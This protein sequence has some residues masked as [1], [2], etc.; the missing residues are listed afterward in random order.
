MLYLRGVFDTTV[1]RRSLRYILA[2]RPDVVVTELPVAHLVLQ[3]APTR[4]WEAIDSFRAE[5]CVGEGESA[6]L[7][8][9]GS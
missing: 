5:R 3:L 7:V 1:R 8:P 2:E 9:P 6:V 4:A